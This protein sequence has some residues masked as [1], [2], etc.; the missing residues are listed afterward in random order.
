MKL[1]LKGHDYKYATEQMLL[2]LFPG[3]RPEYP[4]EPTAAGE[5][6]LVLTLSRT[7]GRATGHAVLTWE[8]RRYSRFARSEERRV[9]KECRSRWSPYH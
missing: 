4:A 6:S 2:M 9:G 7:A 5:D 8:G 1:Y 3:Q